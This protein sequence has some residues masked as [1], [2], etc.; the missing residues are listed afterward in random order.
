M[1]PIFK[2]LSMGILTMS[3][4]LPSSTS[5]ADE[6]IAPSQ[7]ENTGAALDAGFL[8]TDEGK[9]IVEIGEEKARQAW[10][11]ENRK[12]R[13]KRMRPPGQKYYLDLTHFE[14]KDFYYCGPASGQQVLSFHKQ[15]SGS[16]FPLPNQ[17]HLAAVMNTIND[18]ATNS[19]NLAWGLNLYKDDY[20]FADSPYG[21]STP[22]SIQELEVYIKSKLSQRTNVPIVL[23]NTEHMW[24]YKDAAKNYRHYVVVNGYDSNDGTMHIVDPS[25]V[26]DKNGHNLGGEYWEKI[27]NYDMTGYGIGRAVQS[28]RGGNPTLVW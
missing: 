17:D 7:T 21:V 13:V 24:R 16:G 28:A 3:L 10:E 26:K 25:H 22:S 15:D 27:G 23:T 11:Q 1:T 8:K 9:K 19:G 14:Q 12:K 6:N 5:F 4:L 20:D 2:G 18:G